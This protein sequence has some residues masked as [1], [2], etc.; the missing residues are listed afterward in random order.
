[1]E[2]LVELIWICIEMIC[3]FFTYKA[4]FQPRIE[5]KK[6]IFL[7]VFSL[8]AIL[9]VNNI[10]VFFVY[11]YPFFKKGF[12]FVICNAIAIIAF[13]G[14]WYNKLLVATMFYFSLGAIDTVSVYGMAALLKVSVA[15]LV[16]KKWLYTVIVTIGKCI[17]LFISWSLF[18]FYNKEHIKKPNGKKLSLT[19]LFPLISII[20]LFAIFDSYKTQGDLSISAVIFSFILIISNVVIVYLIDNMDR[21]AQ[22]EQELAILNQSMALQT[23]NIRSL[24]KSYRA[25]RTATHEFKHQ[26]QAIYNLLENEDRSLAKRYIQELQATQTSRIFAVNTKHPIVDAILNEKYRIAS[27]NSIDISFKVNDLSNLSINVDAIVVLLSN[28]LDNAIE[29]CQR[30]PEGKAIECILLL[31]ESL[32]LSIRNTS[33]QVD[34]HNGMIETT[35]EPKYEHGFGLIGVRRILNQLGGECVV[36]YSENWFQFVADIP[37]S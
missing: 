18:Y 25:Q 13:D 16:W 35:K 15:D 9:L 23:E 26:L 30:L 27:E 3:L 8:I 33:P 31:D 24:E 34:I 4:F 28:L 29:A 19:F 14:L 10:D 37:I 12:S 36:D 20:M 11:K 1:M 5:T 6:I 21:T 7:L 32:F 22:A 2:Y 17:L